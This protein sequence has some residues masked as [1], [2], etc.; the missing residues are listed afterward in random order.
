MAQTKI[1]K[2]FKLNDGGRE[3]YSTQFK[4]A[5]SR[6]CVTRAIAISAKKDYMKVWNYFAEANAASGRRKTADS[7][8]TTPQYEKYLKE[9]GYS[10]VERK[11]YRYFNE[12]SVKHYKNAIF[13]VS[14]HVV[15]IVNGKINDTYDCMRSG[16]RLLYNVYIK[17]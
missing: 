17:K 2:L 10:K 16:N 6:D 7:G 4:K 14:G 3:K 12:E 9:L 11:K 1:N 8:V 5:T 13:Q 15:A